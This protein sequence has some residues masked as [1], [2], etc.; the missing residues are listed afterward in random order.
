M[1]LSEKELAELFG[2][3]SVSP[4]VLS[5]PAG[6]LGASIKDAS[7]TFISAGNTK[8]PLG[9]LDRIKKDYGDSRGFKKYLKK[10]GY[11]VKVNTSGDIFVKGESGKYED[12]DPLSWRDLPMD[13]LD[14][15]GQIPPMAVDMATQAGMSGLGALATLAASSSGIGGPIAAMLAVPASG[16]ASAFAGEKARQYI[17]KQMGVYDPQDDSVM[18]RDALM[19]TL[20]G[21][22]VPIGTKAVSMA[23]GAVKKIGVDRIANAL[24]IKDIIG[25][26]GKVIEASVPSGESVRKVFA[27]MIGPE[28]VETLVEQA[29]K[30]GLLGRD[31]RVKI[32]DLVGE[33]AEGINKEISGKKIPLEDFNSKA[34]S[35]LK[36]KV[37]D[38]NF[39][40]QAENFEGLLP[41]IF[42]KR[43]APIVENVQ[44]ESTSFIPHE[45]TEMVSKD[46]LGD[47]PEEAIQEAYLKYLNAN[48]PN[49]AMDIIEK[50]QKYRNPNPKIHYEG[51][52]KDYLEALDI[53]DIWKTRNIKYAQTSKSQ[54][55]V[56]S[57]EGFKEQFR[58]TKNV[59]V[60][61]IGYTPK[62]EIIDESY[63][64][65]ER[66]YEVQKK[67]TGKSI[68]KNDPKA[69]YREQMETGVRSVLRDLL[70]GVADNPDN[71]RQ[72]NTLIRDTLAPLQVAM[73]RG[74]AKEAKQ[75]VG[76]V[77]LLRPNPSEL[78][79][80]AAELSDFNDLPWIHSILVKGGKAAQKIDAMPIRN[81]I[82]SL[83]VNEATQVSKG[84]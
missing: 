42:N 46:A 15:A 73:T 38:I 81:L 32:Q 21:G 37:D 53:G 35:M 39:D 12:I 25:D 66:A 76:A 10:L 65:A 61:Q 54:L 36:R 67:L 34:Q 4:D 75:P 62:T 69:E 24:G 44:R 58:P 64:P 23:G 27:N 79:G 83:L 47:V 17:G 74:A 22:A 19:A 68:L 71:Y 82:K 33:A 11:D 50:K 52:P 26:A 77:N 48:K 60:T 30:L 8:S 13:A 14:I 9:I 72:L 43:I 3:Q 55:P 16:A 7:D 28:N 84:I 29:A 70:E 31:R 6:N 18:N 59:P 2:V 78:L 45:Y 5:Q 20:V 56:L 49:L 63:I 57:Y 40:D 80:S 41:S 51:F 1:A